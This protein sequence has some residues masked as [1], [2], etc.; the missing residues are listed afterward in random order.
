MGRFLRHP[1]PFEVAIS[2][3]GTSFKSL[4]SQGF[5]VLQA[6]LRTPKMVDL[7]GFFLSFLPILST[8]RPKA[9]WGRSRNPL[10]YKDKVVLGVFV[11]LAYSLR[12]GAT[13]RRLG[14]GFLA[15][16]KGKTVTVCPLE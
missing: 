10:I 9:V 14:G 15:R 3:T 6:S 8:D 4:K 16:L 7:G 1:S 5:L 11:Y 2:L 12:R 13:F